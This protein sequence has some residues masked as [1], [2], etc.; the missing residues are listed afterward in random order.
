M[1]YINGRKRD[2]GTMRW[3]KLEN[4]PEKKPR[5]SGW[6]IKPQ[7]VEDVLILDIY[8]DKARKKKVLY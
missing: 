6:V 8:K 2:K 7:F 3:K 4:I 1:V 5:K